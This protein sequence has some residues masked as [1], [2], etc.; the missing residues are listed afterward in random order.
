MKN[1]TI[2]ILILLVGLIVGYAQAGTVTVTATGNSSS[3]IFVTSTLQSLPTGIELYIGTF[4]SVS[5]LNT[6]ISTYKSG[7]VGNTTAEAQAAAGT[8]Y[9]DTMTWLTSSS[10]FYNFASNATT[11]SQTPAG[12][13]GKVL[14][15]GTFSRAVNGAASASYTGASA[16]MTETYENYAP[17][18]GSQ[19]WAFFGT[20]TEIAIVTDASWIVPTG[21]AGLTIGTAQLASTGTGNASELLLATYTDY[22]YASTAGVG[23]DLISSVAIAQT[24]IPE[25]SSASLLAL[26]VA[27]LVALRARRKS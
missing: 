16:L 19:L 2:S 14:F 18:T 7:V 21:N 1:K 11:I 17:G 26:G 15:T 24:V 6:V 20:G 23:S 8:L 12:A 13:T 22:A 10:N 5:A 9:S 25:P 4:K 3:P 27:G